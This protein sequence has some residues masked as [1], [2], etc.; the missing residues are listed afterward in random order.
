VYPGC[1]FKLTDYQQVHHGL[2]VLMPLQ[3]RFLLAIKSGYF[4]KRLLGW[5]EDPLNR[6]DADG[7]QVLVV[8]V[9]QGLLEAAYAVLRL[10][11]EEVVPPE[12]GLLDVAKVCCVH[13]ASRCNTWLTTVGQAQRAQ[14]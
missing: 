7:R 11:Y 6:T 13:C 9:E 8:L 5:D 2:L 3:C 10:M 12:M 1:D 4:H 14:H